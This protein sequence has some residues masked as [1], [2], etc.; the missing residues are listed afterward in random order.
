MARK[1]TE[2]LVS[3]EHNTGYSETRLLYRQPQHL[4]E[5]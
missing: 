1:L 3:L 2:D 5:T 4:I